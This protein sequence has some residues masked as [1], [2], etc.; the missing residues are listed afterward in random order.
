MMVEAR[1]EAPASAADGVIPA[2]G[3]V[4]GDALA[5]SDVGQ[6]LDGAT[7]DPGGTVAADADS[8]RGSLRSASGRVVSGLLGAAPGPLIG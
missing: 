2:A 6:A 5:G 7:A 1:I 4:N 3:D 8:S